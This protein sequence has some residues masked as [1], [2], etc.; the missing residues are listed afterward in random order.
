[1]NNRGDQWQAKVKSICIWTC[2][3]I[4]TSLF[5][6][7]LLLVYWI[8]WIKQ[9]FYRNF[10]SFEPILHPV[11]YWSWKIPCKVICLW[12]GHLFVAILTRYSKNSPFIVIYTAVSIASVGIKYG[13]YMYVASCT[14]NILSYKITENWW[15]DSFYAQ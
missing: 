13:S 10:L 6:V 9:H 8:C 3:N 1:M 12:T 4:L 15:N 14:Y 7:L 11:V 2:C 5:F